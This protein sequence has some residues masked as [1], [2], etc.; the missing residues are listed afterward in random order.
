MPDRRYGTAFLSRVQGGAYRPIE[1]T[2]RIQPLWERRFRHPEHRPSQC[3]N[4]P[5]TGFPSLAWQVRVRY[6]HV[7]G[8]WA[9]GPGPH[10]R[11]PLQHRFHGAVWALV[12]DTWPDSF[13]D[14]W[15]LPQGNLGRGTTDSI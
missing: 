13:L 3:C 12:V 10:S 1:C 5:A 9:T 14:V 4:R 2:Y 15:L 6:A 8:A 7:R 11:F